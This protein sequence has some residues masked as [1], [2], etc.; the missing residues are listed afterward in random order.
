M[1]YHALATEFGWAAVILG[2]GGASAQFR[3]ARRLGVEG[4]STATWV[5]FVFMGFFWIT[6][7]VVARSSEVIVGSVIVMPFQLAIVFRLQPWKSP[8]VVLRSFT[9]FVVACVMPTLLWGWVGGVY[10]TGVAMVVNRGPQILEL[11]REEDASGVSVTSWLLGVA[12]TVLWVAYYQTVGLWAALI[13]TAFAGLANL[14]IAMLATWRHL[15][16]RQR[17]TADEVFAF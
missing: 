14:I 17:L 4:I 16:A 10:G 13:S 9:F 12:G 5:L 7:G 3:R 6:Y 15:Q 2:L 11:I 8:Q 1:D